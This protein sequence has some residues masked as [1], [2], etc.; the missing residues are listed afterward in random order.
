[1]AQVTAPVMLDSTGQ[2]LATK[3]DAV[4]TNLANVVGAINN[5]SASGGGGAITI[6]TSELTP[7][8]TILPDH[9][10]HFVYSS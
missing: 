9:C 3:L 2:S 8:T 6:G 4:N 7:G 5:S 10:I 1:M